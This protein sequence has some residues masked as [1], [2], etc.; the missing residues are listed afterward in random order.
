MNFHLL[1]TIT[2]FAIILSLVA[3]V[4][5]HYYIDYVHKRSLSLSSLFIMPLYYF[6]P[7]NSMVKREYEKLK[8]I[9]NAFL[10]LAGLSLILNIV[11]G[12]LLIK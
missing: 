5:T 11:F 3:K 6:R 10:V 7:Y 8:N 1:H 12:V 2:G 4:I 9:C